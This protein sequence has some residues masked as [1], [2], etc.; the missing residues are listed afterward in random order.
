VPYVLALVAAISLA[1]GYVL[2]VRRGRQRE[3]SLNQALEERG[4]KLTLAEHELLRRASI[5]PV[6][7]LPTQQYFQEFLEREW[8][9]ASRER[10]NVSAIMIEVDHFREYNDRAGKAEGDACLKAIAAAMK[11]VVHRPSDVLAR[12]GGPGKFGVVLGHTDRD[13]AMI[14][15]ERLRQAVEKLPR[16]M[17]LSQG[18]ATLMPD[19]EGTWQDIELIAAAEKALTNARDMG[20]NRISAG[21]TA[22]PA[23]SG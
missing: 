2:G 21:N 11:A 22:S 7:E 6:T 10:T 3:K 8:R 12:Y 15:A 20:R 13:G 5:D 18:V 14:I 19:R 4:E 17:T 9:R 16:S 1:V 23:K